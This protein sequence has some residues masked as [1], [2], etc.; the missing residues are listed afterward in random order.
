MGYSL[1][2]KGKNGAD[3]LRKYNIHYTLL[4]LAPN[5]QEATA[6]KYRLDDI[7][8]FIQNQNSCCKNVSQ[9]VWLC[10]CSMFKENLSS[11]T[12]EKHCETCSC[13]QEKIE[14]YGWSTEEV[15]RFLSIPVEE[16]YSIKGG[17]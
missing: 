3:I 17:W 13:D 1:Q 9:A 6:A 8:S 12:E 11:L 15:K 16:I 5:T 10:L 4:G 14:P 7:R 2:V